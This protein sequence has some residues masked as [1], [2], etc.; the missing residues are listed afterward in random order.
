MFL[1]LMLAMIAVIA[2]GWL[3][4][5]LIRVPGNVKS[6]VNVV[7][8]LILVGI[9]LE[10]VNV[11]IPMAG[12]IKVILNIVVVVATCI[13]VFQAVGLWD[14]VVRMWSSFTTKHQISQ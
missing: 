7:L 6:I 3:F 11:Y 9:A 5:T 13:K 1:H 2:V 12:S 10:L 4:N 14:P 8:A